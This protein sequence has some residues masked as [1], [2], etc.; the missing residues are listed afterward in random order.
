[1]LPHEGVFALGLE[2]FG[3]A[4]GGHRS[5]RTHLGDRGLQKPLPDGR[6]PGD[7][8]PE[9]QHLPPPL[10]RQR[11]HRPGDDED[12]EEVSH[13][14]EQEQ[15][16]QQEHGA[17]PFGPPEAPR[18][19]AGL[20]GHGAGDIQV[21]PAIDEEGARQE[22]EPEEAGEHPGLAARHDA[23]CRAY[24]GPMTIDP[25]MSA[26]YSVPATPWV[27]PMTNRLR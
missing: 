5:V 24:Q 16:L 18:L 2:D 9:E 22:Q 17:A 23:D 4:L 6:G 12:E 25:G 11:D 26:A 13:A 8:E 10:P 27:T 19:E 15:R 7:A 14:L 20:L 1:M 21:D 3:G